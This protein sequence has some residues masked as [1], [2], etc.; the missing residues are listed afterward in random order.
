MRP[1]V[2]T[3]APPADGRKGR[4]FTLRLEADD[5]RELERLMFVESQLPWGHPSRHVYG[6]GPPYAFSLGSFLVWAAKQWRPEKSTRR[7]PASG[8]TRSRPA[9]K[10]RRRPPRP[11]KT[12][13][14]GKKRKGGKSR[15]KGRR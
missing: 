6:Q 9:G 13:L 12:R 8:K 14:Q 3:P 4:P 5:R 7:P 1:L 15:R 2:A 10:K 11:G